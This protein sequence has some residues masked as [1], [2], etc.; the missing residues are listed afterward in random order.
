MN[1]AGLLCKKCTVNPAWANNTFDRAYRCCES[2][3]K[4][5][6]RVGRKLGKRRHLNPRTDD[7]ITG[8]KTTRTGLDA[9]MSVENELLLRNDLGVRG[10]H[11]TRIGSNYWV[12]QEKDANFGSNQA[13]VAPST[14]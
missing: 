9:K 12:F 1:R 11:L 14:S 8:D 13:L 7:Q 6:L 4:R 2:N 5:V 3:A 10:N